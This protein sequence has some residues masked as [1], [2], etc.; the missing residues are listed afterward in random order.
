M[1]T[2]ADVLLLTRREP[3]L[4]WGAQLDDD[5]STVRKQ[6]IAA[7]KAADRGDYAPLLALV[8]AVQEE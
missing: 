4:T 6:Y 7:L 1:T 8:R 5:R 2:S 3:R